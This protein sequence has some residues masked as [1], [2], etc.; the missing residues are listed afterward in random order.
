MR[1]QQVSTAPTRIEVRNPVHAALTTVQAASSSLMNPAIRPRATSSPTV[2]STTPLVSEDGWKSAIATIF[3]VGEGA[4]DDNGF[5][6]NSESA[7]DE[8]WMTHFGGVDDPE[9]RCD[10]KPCAFA[11]KENPFYIALPYNDLDDN[12]IK[13]ADAAVIPWNDDSEKKSVV[14]NRWIHVV[15]EGKSCYGQ[16]EDVGPFFEDDRAY[17]FENAEKP[18]NTYGMSAGIDISPAMRDCLGVG[19]VSEVRW[20]H[21]TS[22]EV[23][24]GPWKTIVTTRLSQ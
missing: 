7:W 19:D 22:A 5:I 11:P 15:Y 12:G 9:D 1:F 20:R 24:L 23:P 4:T 17:V 21:V 3:W 13:K 6:H 16:W 10:W 14:K 2:S 18:R 8:A